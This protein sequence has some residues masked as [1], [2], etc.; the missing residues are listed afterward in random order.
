MLARLGQADPDAYLRSIDADELKALIELVV[1]PESWMFRD[2]DAFAAVSRF[3]R[4]RLAQASQ[5]AGAHP[6]AA[7]RRRRR[8]VF[9]RDG[10]AR[11][12]RACRRH[13]FRSTAVDL[14]EVALARLARLGRYTRNAFRG[15]D[16]A[17][18]ATATFTQDGAEYQINPTLREQVNFSRRQ[19]AGAGR[20]RQCGPAD[21]TSFFAATC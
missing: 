14:S 12:W 7:L 13:Q 8:T 17:V 3:V 5:P 1:V 10:P 9:D 11:R 19:S 4:E 15:G 16:L 6:V 21:T 2:A 18:F 20:G